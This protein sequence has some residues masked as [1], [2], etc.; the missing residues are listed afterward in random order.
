MWCR[1]G[2]NWRT[3]ERPTRESHEGMRSPSQFVKSPTPT[4]LGEFEVLLREIVPR[5]EEWLAS[6]LGSGVGGAIPKVECRRMATFAVA[7][8]S[9]MGRGVVAWLNE[10]ATVSVSCMK[11]ARIP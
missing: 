1:R 7:Q 4:T 3:F 10:I 6:E 8:P 9:L 2:E 11:R 5:A